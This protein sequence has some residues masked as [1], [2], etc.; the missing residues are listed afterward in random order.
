VGVLALGGQSL[1]VVML[2]AFF[3]WFLVGLREA[4]WGVGCTLDL[5]ILYFFCFGLFI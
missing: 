2:Q 5:L 3:M 4:F 1:R